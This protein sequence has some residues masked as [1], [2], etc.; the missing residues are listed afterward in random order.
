[1]I[2]IYIIICRKLKNIIYND[3][4][5]L[6]MFENLLTIFSV[7][8]SISLRTPMSRASTNNMSGF[9]SHNGGFEAF[10]SEKR[11][12]VRTYIYYLVIAVTRKCRF[13]TSTDI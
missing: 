12:L 4:I 5:L 10:Q 1:M 11:P 9:V 3:S 8:I 6:E 7:S 2:Y 13:Q